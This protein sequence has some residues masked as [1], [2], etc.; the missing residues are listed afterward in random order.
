MKKI[1]LFILMLAGCTSKPGKTMHEST[2][3]AVIG[4]ADSMTSIVVVRSKRKQK[5]QK[6]YLMYLFMIKAKE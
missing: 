6:V 3:T 4:G 5:L 2:S 1:F